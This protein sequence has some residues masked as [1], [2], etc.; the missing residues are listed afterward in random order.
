VGGAGAAAAS[1]AGDF[2]RVRGVKLVVVVVDCVAVAVVSGQP[3]A[4]ALEA[5]YVAAAQAGDHQP[6]DGFGADGTARSSAFS[7]F[8][9]GTFCTVPADG[10][11]VPFDGF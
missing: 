5:D 7:A 2:G 9:D 8:G 1:W 6:G 10:N 3:H 11:A 4:V